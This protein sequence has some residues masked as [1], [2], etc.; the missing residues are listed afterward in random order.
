MLSALGPLVAGFPCK[1]AFVLQLFQFY[2][3]VNTNTNINCCLKIMF[4]EYM[5]IHVWD[6][7]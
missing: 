7:K 5:V 6:A 4:G 2:H 3:V 1:V